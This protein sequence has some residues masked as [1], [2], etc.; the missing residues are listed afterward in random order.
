MLDPEE[1]P[2]QEQTLT[3]DHG[4]NIQRVLVEFGLRD[5]QL[6]DFSSNVNAR[7]LPPRAAERIARDA[8]NLALLQRYPDV[9][10]LELRRALSAKHRIGEDCIVI[11]A[12]AAELIAASIRALRARTC[13][14]P[15]P[16]F[17]EY[18]FA[19]T[20]SGCAFNS[21]RLEPE[22]DFHLD[23][24]KV[25][26]VLDHG[27]YTLL[28]LNNPHNPSGVLVPPDSVLRIIDAAQRVNTSVI[29]DE[30]F[31]DYCPSASLTRE[32]AE[33]PSVIALRS[34]TKFYGCPGLRVGYAVATP[35]LAANITAQLQPWPV[36]VLALNGAAE[37][38]HDREFEIASVELNER[39]RS[40]VAE[41]LR[42]LGFRIYPSAANFL[43]MQVPGAGLSATQIW[44]SLITG[45]YIHLRNCDSFEG[46]SVGHYLRAAIRSAAE[47]DGLVGALRQI[48]ER[49]K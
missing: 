5:V 1:T 35:S 6:V 16:A 41:N 12:G 30:A 13:L 2:S 32:A 14:C 7:G 19:C 21:F 34:L 29:L 24:D 31:V 4:G 20:A 40:R 49:R 8:A 3:R 18:R 28:I 48:L 23:V 47:N 45:Y 25:C 11:G 22:E 36:T 46:L 10:A 39:E 15:I 38:L 33:M 27:A 9:R 43:F 17:S 37:A 42:D 44:S 26:R